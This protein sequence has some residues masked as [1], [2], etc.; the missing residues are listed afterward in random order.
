MLGSVGMALVC[1]T[2]LCEILGE[3]TEPHGAKG[4]LCAENLSNA[5]GATVCGK[6]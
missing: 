6:P 2:R 3:L 4:P 1:V 5:S